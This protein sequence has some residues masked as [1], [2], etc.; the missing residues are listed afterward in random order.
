[1]SFERAPARIVSASADEVNDVLTLTGAFETPSDKK[2]EVFKQSGCHFL[3][4]GI[5]ISNWADVVVAVCIS[6][7]TELALFTLGAL[8]HFDSG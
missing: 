3:N 4:Q 5:E 8:R 2:A 1:M 7:I 6:E